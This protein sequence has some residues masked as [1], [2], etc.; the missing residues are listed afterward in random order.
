VNA[1]RTGAVTYSGQRQFT[2]HLANARKYFP[3]RNGPDGEPIYVMTKDRRNSP[4]KI[5]IA[6][7]GCLS[8]RAYLDGG[9]GGVKAKGSRQGSDWKMY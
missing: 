3:G 1:W 7:A 6:V 5:D 9:A 4:H 2:E 8:W